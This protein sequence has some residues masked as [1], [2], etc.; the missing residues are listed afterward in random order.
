MRLIYQAIRTIR[1]TGTQQSQ[2]ASLLPWNP[3]Y[4][5]DR[6]STPA[7]N[8]RLEAS[9]T[10]PKRFPQGNLLILREHANEREPR[11]WAAQPTP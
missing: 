2:N 3:C 10:R 5:T 1:S 4:Y 6:Q 9:L 11:C 8:G 7:R